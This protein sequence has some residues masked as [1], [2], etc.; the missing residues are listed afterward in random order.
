MKKICNNCK[1]EK[2]LSTFHNDKGRKDGKAI[3]CKTCKREKA[4]QYNSTHKEEIHLKNKIYYQENIEE[5][6]Q[7]IAQYRIENRDKVLELSRKVSKRHYQNNKEDY[8]RRSSERRALKKG[9]TV[10]YMPNNIKEIHLF[11]Q[12]DCC[13]ICWEPIEEEYPHPDIHLEHIVPLS[14]GGEHSLE[15]TQVAHRV[16]NRRK[17]ARNME[18]YEEYLVCLGEL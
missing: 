9:A 10:G 14:R 6:R 4:H 11:M 13:A 1:G 5:I 17:W 15:N 16:C 12:R 8:Y 7:R 2:S 3:Y 18:E